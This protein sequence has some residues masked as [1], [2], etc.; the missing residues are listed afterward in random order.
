MT[1]WIIL[2]V[3]IAGVLA[4]LWLLRLPRMLLGF[5][6]AATMLGATGYAWQGRP[7]LAGSDANARRPSAA[8]DPEIMGLRQAMFGRFQRSDGYFAA[9]DALS[10]AGNARAGA[11][12]MLA[13]VRGAPD[14]VALWT[15]LGDALARADDTPSPAA[16]LAFAQ[17]RRINPQHPAPLFFEGLA[18]VRAGDLDSAR[19]YWVMAARLSPAGAGYGEDMRRRVE[20]LDMLRE[21]RQAM[22]QQMRGAPA[23]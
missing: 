8:L 19:P 1:G 10:R 15:G 5:A 9:S 4:A 22:Q 11:Q 17:A 23:M 21:M 16:R 6:G 13:A 3:A 14:D 2:L 20:L 12:V 7:A 18:H